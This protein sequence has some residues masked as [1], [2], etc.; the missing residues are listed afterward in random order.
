ML[1]EKSAKDS[2]EQQVAKYEEGSAEVADET[3]KYITTKKPFL[4]LAYFGAVDIAGHK[5]G[6]DTPGYYASLTRMDANVGKVLAALKTAGI[7]KDTLVL[8][9]SDHGGFGKKHGGTYRP[10][11]IQ[12]PWII[13][14]P[15]VKRGYTIKA[16]VVHTDTAATIAHALGLTAPQCWRGRPALEVFETR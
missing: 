5:L 11:V 9:I 14:G 3:V 13:A 2:P 1:K 16:P 7:E 15:G 8:L 6:H 10:E 4:A 12:T